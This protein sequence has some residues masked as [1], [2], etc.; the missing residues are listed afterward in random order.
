M[1]KWF[2]PATIAA[3][4]ALTTT[5]FAAEP[6]FEQNG[7]KYEFGHFTVEAVELNANAEDFNE[8][9]D[10]S[11]YHIMDYTAA[12]PMADSYDANGVTDANNTSSTYVVT[13]ADQA[14]VID[15]GN[16]A[17]ATAGHF[18]EDA[19]DQ[20]VLDAI[21]AEFKEL[22]QS[23]AGDRKITVAITHNHGDHVGYIT[24][25]AGEGYPLYFAEGDYNERF[26]RTYGESFAQYDLTLFTP[27]ELTIDLG[28]VA[29]ESIDCKGHTDASVLYLL[30]TPVVHYTYNDAGE[31]TDSS[32]TYYLFAGDA[33]GSGSTGWFFS[34]AG[35]DL[36]SESIVAVEAKMAATVDYND[37]LGG[38]EK[39][40]AVLHIL[41]G[42][43]WQIWNRFG[44]C[45]MDIRY[46][47]NLKTLTEKIP[48]GTWV[49]EGTDGKTLEELLQEGYVVT[50]PTGAWLD[51]SIYYGPELDAV[52]GIT[53]STATLNEIA[54][55]TTEEPAAN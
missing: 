46:I 17:P 33:V 12:V 23:L 8:N 2:I 13:T 38:E 34:K 26:Q 54:G 45:A 6:V 52:A 7:D 37:Y 19:E 25:L 31:A 18:G 39:H 9:G 55:I 1:K 16:G 41:G 42:H 44:T 29:L 49:A 5:L 32:A 53:T 15:L 51:T 50:K 48:E 14:L 10:V 21:D 47:E 27:G 24:A 36:F 40:D 11:I 3:A 22:I 20:A 4:M 35:I 43:G 28:D 30:T